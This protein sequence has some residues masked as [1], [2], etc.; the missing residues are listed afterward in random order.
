MSSYRGNSNARRASFNAGIKNRRGRS[1]DY[2]SNPPPRRGTLGSSYTQD[3]PKTT[4]S[5][6]FQN[7]RASDQRATSPAP[8]EQLRQQTPPPLSVPRSRFNRDSNPRD[9]NARTGPV[10]REYKDTYTKD[11]YRHKSSVYKGAASSGPSSRNRFEGHQNNANTGRLP[12][13]KLYKG[14]PNGRGGA[15][16]VTDNRP[17]KKSRFDKTAKPAETMATVRKESPRPVLLPPKPVKKFTIVSEDL[18]FKKLKQCGEGTYGKVFKVENL[19]RLDKKNSL[20]AIKRLRLETER[21]GF[22][23]TSIREI[24]LLQRMSTKKRNNNISILNEILI[25]KEEN[26]DPNIPTK[27]SINMVF[28]YCQMDLFS[29]LE[30]S[31]STDLTFGHIKNIGK[32]LLM[33][34]DF[35]HSNNIIHRDIK[36]SN[37]LINGQGGLKITDFGLA[38]I[39]SSQHQISES[40][41]VHGSL[42]NRV[43]T[44][45]YRP[46]ELLIGSTN[47]SYEVDMWGCGCLL[48]QLVNKKSPFQGQSD[49]Q[50][51]CD[52]I[53][54]LGMPDLSNLPKLFEYP[55]TFLMLSKL[56]ELNTNKSSGNDKDMIFD[57][58]INSKEESLLEVIKG[59]LL[60]NPLERFD[61]KKCLTYSCFKEES[62]LQ[63][64]NITE[65]QEYHEYE[66]KK[67]RREQRKAANKP[68]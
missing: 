8:Q 24:K 48:L 49:I 66:V 34:M 19:N 41:S 9:A 10:G 46:I 17:Y 28:E 50:T 58:L 16:F 11:E 57:R 29:F 23:I 42:T 13:G 43:I 30:K 20:V 64:L 40:S 37:I 7:V 67:E 1:R 47:Y 35:L 5:S 52:I 55:W 56:G 4:P 3:E 12:A 45:W 53:Q 14:K 39:V 36:P 54:K 2:H 68:R 26:L 59:L 60:Y 31:S 21:D 51:L 63:E 44:L 65:D 15:Q 38:R 6:R 25:L 33:G 27:N 22:P 62:Q 61:A 32:Q 18:S